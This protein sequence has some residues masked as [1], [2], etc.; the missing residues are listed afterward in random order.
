[1]KTRQ[2]RYKMIGGLIILA[3]VF[4]A[5]GCSFKSDGP[6]AAGASQTGGS[7]YSESTQSNA[8]EVYAG[9][10][11]D[12]V[13]LET[14]DESEIKECTHEENGWYEIAFGDRRGYIDKRQLIEELAQEEI[15]LLVHS[16]PD[17]NISTSKKIHCIDLY[18][19]LPGEADVYTGPSPSHQKSTSLPA[20]TEVKLLQLVS[21]ASSI[22]ALTGFY[23]IEY[24]V[25]TGLRRGYV[26]ESVL[27]DW[28]NPLRDFDSV[29]AN[30]AEIIYQ[31]KSYY[32]STGIVNP[33]Q[34][35]AGWKLEET[36]SLTHSEFNI[37]SGVTSL[38]AGNKLDEEDLTAQKHWLYDT[39]EKR[40]IEGATASGDRRYTIT[41]VGLEGLG[42]LNSFLEGLNQSY[43]FEVELQRYGAEGK[44]AILI[45]SPMDGAAGKKATYSGEQVEHF[46][47]SYFPDIEDASGYKLDAEFAAYSEKDIPYGY[48]LFFDT[49][50]NAYLKPILR[51]NTRFKIYR[52]S[53]TV[54]DITFMVANSVMKV[55][56]EEQIDEILSLMAE[57]GLTLGNPSL[58]YEALY[59]TYL[60]NGQW[61]SDIKEVAGNFG[62]PID[63]DFLAQFSLVEKRIG[64]I[65]GDSIPELYVRFDITD[66]A[67][68][69][70]SPSLTALCTIE[71]DEVQMHFGENYSGGTIGGGTIS[72]AQH[73]ED[74]RLFICTVNTAGGFGGYYRNT[75]YYECTGSMALA[76]SCE[77]WNQRIGDFDNLHQPYYEDGQNATVYCVD[78]RQCTRE[79]YENL[80]GSFTMLAIQD[81]FTGE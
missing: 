62:V 58:D 77:V 12:Y 20:G 23:R 54:Q 16:P 76:Y 32:S 78:D 55:E 65:S 9:P 41:K 37:W 61:K 29:K 49:D 73:N 59:D 52:D 34:V 68:P 18:W 38:I 80:E 47:R 48:F 21:A 40:W 45:G 7:V 3:I 26:Q 81:V 5:A 75:E 6:S 66:S 17:Q 15:P 56:D 8:L 53:E 63:D 43:S 4:Q 67:G 39:S 13:W 57:N 46:V 42:L 31:G 64:D 28:Y 36:F 22:S 24:P 74:G 2:K 79:E 70:G 11:T 71:N 19:N 72:F 25:D 1:M 50:L 33:N 60:S 44:I 14:I 69:K 10:G 27:M 30:N 35:P 51:Q